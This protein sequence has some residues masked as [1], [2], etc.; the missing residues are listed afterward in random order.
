VSGLLWR[1]GVDTPDYTADDLTG[2]G[3]KTTGG[4]WNRKGT[5]ILYTSESIAL[6]ALETWVH[7]NAGDLPLNRYLVRFDVPAAIWKRTIVFDATAGAGWDTLP[8]GRVSLDAGDGWAAAGASALMRVPSVVVPE[9][10][11]VLINPHHPDAGSIRVRKI[12]KWTYD[13]RLRKAT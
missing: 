12:R 10:C 11:N 2:A 8:E 9:E 6:A 3:A 1:I 13:A 7:F 4:R 5:A